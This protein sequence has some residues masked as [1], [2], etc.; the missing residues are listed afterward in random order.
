MSDLVDRLADK[1][2]VAHAARAGRSRHSPRSTSSS[3]RPCAG[4]SST[5]LRPTPAEW[6]EARW[7]PNEVFARL[8]ELGY[9]GL[10]FPARVRR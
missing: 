8:A 5:E 10:K 1:A 4:S 7:F 6:E 9:I 2:G 3:A